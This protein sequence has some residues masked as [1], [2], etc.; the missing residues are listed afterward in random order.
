MYSNIHE[1]R[2]AEC[3][4]AS[5]TVQQPSSSPTTAAQFLGYMWCKEQEVPTKL[6]SDLHLCAMAYTPANALEF[7]YTGIQRHK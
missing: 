5:K 7:V 1:L 4:N 6:S 3:Y 2:F